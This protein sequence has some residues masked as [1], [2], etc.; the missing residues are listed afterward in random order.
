MDTGVEFE[1]RLR[2]VG[3]E[4]YHHRH[5]FNR[6]MHA[7]TLTP[8]EI[9]TWVLN[10]YYYQTRIPRK[11]AIILAKADDPSFRRE[12]V[13]RIHDHDGERAGQ[14]G[15]EL[16]LRLAA[17]VGLDRQVVESLHEVLPGVREACDDY[18]RLVESE[19]LL[20]CV[21][22]SLTELFSG[23]LLRERV[24]AFEKH[25]PWVDTEGLRYFRSRTEIAPRDASFG[26]RYVL[27]NAR[28]PS[29]QEHCVA[30]LER[31]CEVLWRLLDAVEAAFRRLR[32]SR[33]ADCRF[34]EKAERWVLILPERL[35]RLNG[36]GHEILE[37]CDGRR[38]VDELVKTLRTR[39]PAAPELV[40]EVDRFLG[41][42][43]RLGA[44]ELVS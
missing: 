1:R 42:L 39:H 38:S 35:I 33:H 32:V 27:E 2:H 40:S 34:D 12:W 20:G 29:Q 30:A 21:A 8:Q 28:T 10:R 17:A 15:L 6:R 41:R 23:D 18:V 7:G 13:R 31:K 9:R 22:A 37:L 25:Y 26:L 5:P 43:E 24:T 11:D 3:E 16:W 19:D 36:S 4:R 44:L 14:G